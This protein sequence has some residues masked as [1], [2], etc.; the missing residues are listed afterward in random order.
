MLNSLNNKYLTVPEFFGL[1]SAQIKILKNSNNRDPL[2]PNGPSTVASLAPRAQT[3]LNNSASAKR[4]R[5]LGSVDTANLSKG[6]IKSGLHTNFNLFDPQ[7]K[8]IA[9]KYL[10]PLKSVDVPHI[11]S[12][13]ASATSNQPL[14][15]KDIDPKQAYL[16]L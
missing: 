15:H 8:K 14:L 1:G 9:I 13:G 12:T 4:E 3:L 10:Q 7:I 2:S 5:R 6:N 16:E 11:H